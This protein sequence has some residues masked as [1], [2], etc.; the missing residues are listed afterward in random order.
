MFYHTF[1]APEGKYGVNSVAKLQKYSDTLKYIKVKNIF[2]D[3]F[4]ACFFGV[5]VFL[6]YICK[7]K[8]N[9]ARKVNELTR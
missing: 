2:A 4:F 3:V 9:Q 8:T 5:S 7:G 1:T 6:L